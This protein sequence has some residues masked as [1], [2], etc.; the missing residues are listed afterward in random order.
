MKDKT[1]YTIFAIMLLVLVGAGLVLA[2]KNTNETKKEQ[3]MQKEVSIQEM[4]KDNPEKMQSK[5]TKHMLRQEEVKIR[6]DAKKTLVSTND[7]YGMVPLKEGFLLLEEGNLVGGELVSDM[8][9]LTSDDLTGALKERLEKHLK[10]EDFFATEQFPTSKFVITG[11][12]SLEK[13][14]FLITGDLTIKGITEKIEF[15]ATIISDEK[16]ISIKAT[17]QIDRTRWNVRFGSD[18]FFDNLGNNRIDDI[19]KLSIEVSTKK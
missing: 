15:P 8:A 2:R 6:W 4:T 13:T 5:G 10:S 14:N 12:T 1:I 16:M 7:H 18:K 11:V 9:N 3:M 17:P 19:I